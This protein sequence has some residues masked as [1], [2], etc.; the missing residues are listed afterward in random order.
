MKIIPFS[1]D[2]PKLR[3]EIFTTVRKYSDRFYRSSRGELFNVLVDGR[4]K[5]AARLLEVFV[6]DD[7]R[8]PGPA[9]Q[10]GESR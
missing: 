6:V 10:E 1:F 8:G 7:S 9:V 5:F 4:V 2:Y 3:H